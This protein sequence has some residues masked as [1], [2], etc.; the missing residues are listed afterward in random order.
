MLAQGVEL[1]VLDEN[2]L[3]IIFL[4]ERLGQDFLRVQRIPVRQE[5]V[6]FG[7]A[8]RRF[9]QTLPLRVFPDVGQDATDV[10]SNGL[11]RIHPVVIDTP[12]SGWRQDIIVFVQVRMGRMIRGNGMGSTM[13]VATD[14]TERDVALLAHDDWM[15]WP[16]WWA[17]PVLDGRG[18]YSVFGD[19]LRL[20]YQTGLLYTAWRWVTE[21]RPCTPNRALQKRSFVA[22]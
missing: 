7:H 2:H 1:D 17:R 3:V 14:G 21:I 11:G 12:I 18:E 20:R 16:E 9:Q 5:L 8:F 19:R 22:L 13:P 10:G 6:R 15:L 4:E